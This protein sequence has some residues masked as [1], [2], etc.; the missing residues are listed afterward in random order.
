V[1]HHHDKGI[2]DAIQTCI[3]DLLFTRANPIEA[4]VVDGISAHDRKRS[5]STTRLSSDLA[6]SIDAPVKSSKG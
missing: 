1:G 5:R 2:Q 3:G 6:S 4:K